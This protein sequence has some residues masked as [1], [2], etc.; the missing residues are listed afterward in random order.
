[1]NYYDIL[2]ID[3]GASP[4]DIRRA[5]KKKALESHPDRP[6]GNESKFR[7]VNEAY[8]VLSNTEKRKVYDQYGKEGLDRGNGNDAEADLKSFFA[9]MDPFRVFREMFPEVYGMSQHPETCNPGREGKVQRPQDIYFPLHLKFQEVYNG[10][11]KSLAVRRRCFC[12]L[13]NGYGIQSTTTTD[14]ETNTF[15]EGENG[16][17]ST[18]ISPHSDNGV[19]KGAALPLYPISIRCIQCNGTGKQ[20]MMQKSYLASPEFTQGFCSFC[21]GEG[22]R[23]PISAVKCPTCHGTRLVEERA[24]FSVNIEAG[25]PEGYRIVCQGEGDDS[26]LCGEK[27]GD[28]ILKITSELPAGWSRIG[29]H[30]IHRLPISLAA[31]IRGISQ[32]VSHPNGHDFLFSVSQVV[33]PNIVLGRELFSPWFVLDWGFCEFQEEE[34]G[35]TII[36][37]DIQFPSALAINKEEQE[38]FWTIHG[39]GQDDMI[40]IPQPIIRQAQTP[41]EK[42]ILQILFSKL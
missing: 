19:L 8:E 30:L 33:K 36:L 37:L 24:I 23:I 21:Q 11:K 5:Y 26:L 22:M 41:K 17:N 2:E 20:T 15:E 32:V 16:V 6:K 29:Q 14:T 12:K 27:R 9:T 10:C 1:M 18:P 28:V 31:C 3:K 40:G 38:Q 39:K 4:D 13:C 35:S 7:Q 42:Q 25:T 34:M